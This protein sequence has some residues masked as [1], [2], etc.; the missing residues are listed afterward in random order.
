[1]IKRSILVIFFCCAIFVVHAQIC[2]VKVNVFLGTSGDH[3]QL[4]PVASYPFSML[5]MGPQTYPNTHT[6]YEHKAKV[7]LGFT[8]GRLEGVGCMGSGGNILIKPFVGN[9]DNELLKKTERGS[10]GYY[11]VSLKNGISCRFTLKEKSGIENYRFPNEKHGFLIDL[12][13]ALVNGFVAEE[14]T[15]TGQT[16]SGWIESGTT[17]R[18]G[19]FRVYY[20]LS[21]DQPVTYIDST[22]HTFTILAKTRDITLRIAFSSL[23]EAYAKAAINKQSFEQVKGA[24]TAAWTR[25]LS[26]IKVTGDPKEERVFE[27]LLYRCLHA[28]FDINEPNGIY[29]GSDGKVYHTNNKAYSG[30]TIWDNYKTTLPLLSLIAPD[31]YRDMVTS[32]ANLYRFG[33]KNWATKTE[34]SNTV[35]T[36]HAIVVL[37]DAYRKGY[38]VD[39]VGIRDSLLKETDQLDFG[40]PDK[41]LESSYDVWAMAQI[42]GILH[43]D[44]LSKVYLS[45]AADW[46]IYWNKDFKDLSKPDVDDLNARHMYQG[47]IWQYRWFAPFDQKHLIEACG[48]ET[49]YL[50]QLDEFFNGDYYNAANE[51]DIQVPYMYNFTSQPWKSQNVIRKYAKDTV[52]QYYE[53]NNYRGI[54]PQIKRVYNNRPDGFLQTMDDDMGAMSAWYILAAIGLS[55]ACVGYPIYYLHVPLFK[56]VSIGKLDIIVNGDGRYIQSTKLNG[57]NLGRNW[58]TQ[59]EIMRG[60]KLNITASTMPNKQFGIHNQFITT[61]KSN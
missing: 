44:S 57:M 56:K 19:T 7:F 53:D 6:G 51:P 20:N 59:Q 48:G 49:E 41:A 5:D 50:K 52:T 14:H 18:V 27:S 47:T 13:H 45:K 58:L 23:S 10:P 40:K 12:S 54:D 46:K 21:F 9:P 42:L 22:E 28:P 36:E 24:A 61:I 26:R 2:D 29:R 16:I 35:R 32:I 60:G 1:M 15:V 34:P 39:F 3:G 8:H 11:A 33:K 37:L 55:P 30:W 4:S 38:R 25:E 17:C 31:R 43:E